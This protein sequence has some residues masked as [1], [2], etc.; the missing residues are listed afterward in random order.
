[1]EMVLTLIYFFL[2][3]IRFAKEFMKKTL[4]VFIAP[5]TGC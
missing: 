2:A 3:G 5:R 4:T 1:M